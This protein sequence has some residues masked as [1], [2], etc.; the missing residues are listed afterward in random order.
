MLNTP[1]GYSQSNG[2]LA[3]REVL[4]SHYPGAT[5]DQ[6]EVT[7]GTSEANYLVALTL[8]SAGDEVAFEVPNYMQLWGVP[9]S[10]GAVV[11]TFRLR[12][13]QGGSRTGRSSSGP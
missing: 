10:L 9:Q 5:V 8:L 13:R 2:T 1:L 11:R 6:I 12:P 4:T 3:L 7:N